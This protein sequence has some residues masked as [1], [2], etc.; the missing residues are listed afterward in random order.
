MLQLIH[1]F[2]SSFLFVFKIT[3]WLT[4]KKSTELHPWLF[5]LSINGTSCYWRPVSNGSLS[6]RSFPLVLGE[7][8]M[9]AAL[10]ISLSTDIRA[11]ECKHHLETAVFPLEQVWCWWRE[12]LSESATICTVCDQCCRERAIIICATDRKALQQR[13]NMLLYSP[14]LSLA[15]DIKRWGVEMCDEVWHGVWFCSESPTSWKIL[16]ILVQGSLHIRI[17]ALVPL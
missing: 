13:S 9:P 15:S 5:S 2:A 17:K 3:S 11:P 10:G 6:N 16:W 1:C 7:G 14:W 8:S 4:F 12:T